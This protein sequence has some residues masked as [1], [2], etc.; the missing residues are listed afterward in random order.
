MDIFEIVRSKI[1]RLINIQM[2]SGVQPE[3]LANNIYINDYE[4]IAFHKE[5]KIVVGEL[6]F[7]EELNGCYKVTTLR[8]IYVVTL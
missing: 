8:Y 2:T 3:D 6:K 5:N 4:S 1:D 7:R